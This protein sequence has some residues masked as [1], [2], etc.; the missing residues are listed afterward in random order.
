[1][2]KVRLILIPTLFLLTSCATSVL[3]NTP[4]T[5]KTDKNTDRYYVKSFSIELGE[6]VRTKENQKKLKTLTSIFESRLKERNVASKNIIKANLKIKITTFKIKGVFGRVN[7][8]L[9]G[10]DEV[11]SEVKLIAADGRIIK[12]Y[13]SE[14]SHKTIPQEDLLYRLVSSHI[15]HEIFGDEKEI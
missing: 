12:S 5:L 10:A 6:E 11:V 14:L 15:L 4:S 3:K 8:A 2:N 1:M 9:G 13:K 7:K